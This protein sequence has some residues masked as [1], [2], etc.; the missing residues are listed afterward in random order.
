MRGIY[1]REMFETCTRWPRCCRPPRITPVL[2]HHFPIPEFQRG[3]ETMGRGSRESHP[4]GAAQLSVGGGEERGARSVHITHRF[5]PSLDRLVWM[6]GRRA[7]ES[8]IGASPDV[9]LV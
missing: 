2:T 3:F 7:A 1:G 6:E 9:E 5:R 4:R 8:V